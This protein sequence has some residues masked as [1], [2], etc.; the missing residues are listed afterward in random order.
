MR[1][2]GDHPFVLVSLAALLAGCTGPL[3]LAHA[4]RPREDRAFQQAL[5]KYD[6][7]PK[8]AWLHHR[9]EQL[10]VTYEE[11]RA[12]DE[13]LARGPNPFKTSDVQAVSYG[14][15]M[16][17]EYCMKCH[18]E[19]AD[20]DGWMASR[21]HRPKNFRNAITRMAVVLSGGPPDDWFEA[22]RDGKGPQVK[23]E[24]GTSR[25]MPAFGDKLANEQIWMILT[26]LASHD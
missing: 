26:Y 16:Y 25:A 19:N 9:A 24:Q 8:E 22:V 14:A 1:A 10:G 17:A 5:Q 6:G 2:M 3:P 20:G 15:A 11:M 18:G 13:A 23:Y 21:D 4:L 7:S 12:R